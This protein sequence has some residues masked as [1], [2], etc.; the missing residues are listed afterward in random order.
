M[1]RTIAQIAGWDASNARGK[2]AVNIV[3]CSDVGFFMCFPS[4]TVCAR[5]F[6]TTAS[7][8]FSSRERVATSSLLMVCFSLGMVRMNRMDERVTSINDFRVAAT[9][10]FRVASS[11]PSLDTST[12]HRLS[13]KMQHLRPNNAA[14]YRK[15]NWVERRS[16]LLAATGWLIC[17]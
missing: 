4:C 15:Q 12:F 11:T 17:T 5:M 1:H 10:S 7:P 2:S 13:P 16:D 8:T 6:V 9:S 14:E 3:R